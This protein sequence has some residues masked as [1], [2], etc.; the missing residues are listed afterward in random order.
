MLLFC[1]LLPLS[2]HISSD[3]AES[4]GTKCLAV[5]AYY[6]DTKCLN[7]QSGEKFYWETV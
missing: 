5:A 1:L 2:G 6:P 7:N 3:N 4:S